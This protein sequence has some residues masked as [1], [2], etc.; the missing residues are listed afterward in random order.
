MP[1]REKLVLSNLGQPPIFYNIIEIEDDFRGIRR[2]RRPRKYKS[3]LTAVM[4]WNVWE[5]TLAF[6]TQWVCGQDNLINLIQKNLQHYLH[7]KKM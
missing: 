5:L 1:P 3:S 4:M 6:L 7:I 2:V